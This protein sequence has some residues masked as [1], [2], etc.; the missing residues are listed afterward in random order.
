MDTRGGIAQGPLK[1][2]EDWDD[3]VATRYTE[4]RNTTEFRNY[5]SEANPSIAEFYRQTTRSRRSISSSEKSRST[6]R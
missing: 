6:V 4:G 5:T 1:H 3:F 2:V